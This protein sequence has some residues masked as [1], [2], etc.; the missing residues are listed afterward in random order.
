M[1]PFVIKLNDIAGNPVVPTRIQV[2]RTGTFSDPRYGTFDITPEQL[3]SMKANFDNK[4]RGVDIAVDYSHES[5][6]EAAGWIEEVSLEE[7]QGQT[8]LW[9]TVKWTEKAR[10]SLS[11]KEYRYVSADFMFDY[12]DNETDKHYGPCLLGAGLTNRPV[13]KEMNPIIELQEGKGKKMS[14]DSSK[15]PPGKGDTEDDANDSDMEKTVA[16]LKEKVSAL[17][18]QASEGTS[19]GKKANPSDGGKD[20]DGDDSAVEGEGD[21]DDDTSDEGDDVPGLKKKMAKM[22]AKL[23][24]YEAAQKSMSEELAVNK[25]KAAFSVMLSEGKVVKAQEE[26]YL[27]GDMDKF[28]SL[29]QAVK[30]SKSGHSREEGGVNSITLTEHP[31][32]DEVIQLAEK[33][34]SDKKASDIGDATSKVLKAHPELLRRYIA[35]TTHA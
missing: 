7:H 13:I 17:E 35:E 27:K 4:V 5:D 23:A 6:M 34:V 8:Q 20:S 14:K 25:K 26:A 16:E 24:S 33:M 12:V 3:Q 15:V 29:Q 30:L 2:L 10:I 11:D 22:A 28:A 32:Q 9:A 18:K 1:P 21:G 31:A 19:K